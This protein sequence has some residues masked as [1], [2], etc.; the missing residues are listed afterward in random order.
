M[1]RKLALLAFALCLTAPAAHAQA[2]AKKVEIPTPEFPTDSSGRIIF[3]R[4][5]YAYPG[6]GRRDPFAS[7]DR[8]R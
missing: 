3:K 2:A 5:T 1:M 7:P 6:D 4:E 8:D